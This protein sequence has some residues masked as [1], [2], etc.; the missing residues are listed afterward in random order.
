MTYEI[1]RSLDGQ[2]VFKKGEA[3]TGVR[4]VRCFPW[5][6]PSRY[7][8]LRDEKD[9]EVALISDLSTLPEESRRALE[10]A[11]AE[12]GFVLEVIGIESQEEE[13][14]LRNWK[15]RTRQGVRTFQTK[16]DSWPRRVPGGGLLI[17]DVA[18]DLFYI[19]EPEK[20]DEKSRAHL[21]AFVD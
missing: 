21:W 19:A 16:L 15:V 14:E 9:R 20:L 8:S 10:E 17:Q 18:G 6:E 5:S 7:F 1:Q 13:F 12:A 11:L 4:L 2:L 3:R